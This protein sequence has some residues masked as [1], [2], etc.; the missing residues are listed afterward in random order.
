MP[1]AARTLY[2]Q[3]NPAHAQRSLRAGRVAR[4]YSSMQYDMCIK[5]G[6]WV[7]AE[8][9]YGDNGSFAWGQFSSSAN[10]R[11]TNN[12]WRSRGDHCRCAEQAERTIRGYRCWFEHQQRKLDGAIIR[13]VPT[14]LHSVR[15]FHVQLAQSFYDFYSSGDVM[16]GFVPA[17]DTGDGGWWLRVTPAVQNGLSGT[18][19]TEIRRTTQIIRRFLTC[20]RHN[21]A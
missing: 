11:A 2:T 13:S 6:G 9:A 14:R 21:H 20:P 15:G 4:D 8:Y 5:M 16:W 12:T 3:N 7:R 19:A 1:L 18:L 10:N 17:S